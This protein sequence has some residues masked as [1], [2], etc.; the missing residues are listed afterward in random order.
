M[1]GH[2]IPFHLPRLSTTLDGQ[3]DRRHR[4]HQSFLSY[5]HLQTVTLGL[6]HHLP[7]RCRG[8]KPRTSDHVSSQ[9]RVR[10]LL[11]NHETSAEHRM[12]SFGC[13]SPTLQ[14]PI[15]AISYIQ[16]TGNVAVQLDR[17]VKRVYRVIRGSRW[18]LPRGTRVDMFLFEV[19]TG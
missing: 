15:S 18:R 5:L 12:R 6:Y 14:N 1:D 3:L 19:K 11:I 17:D 8:R 10:S 13:H 2:R 4:V 9:P 16:E 7:T